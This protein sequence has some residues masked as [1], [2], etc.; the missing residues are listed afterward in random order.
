MIPFVNPPGHRY[1]LMGYLFLILVAVAAVEL[2]QWRIWYK[3]G[4]IVVGLGLVSGHFWLYP[5]GIAQG[6]DSS[7]AHLPVFALQEKTKAYFE[8]NGIP[9]KEVCADF[10]FLHTPYDTYVVPDKGDGWYRN[11]LEVTGCDWV[12]NSNLING[13]SNEQLAEFQ[14][15]ARWEMKAEYTARGMWVQIFHRR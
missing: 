1:F 4:L 6:W 8:T 13:Y 2:G 5:K 3:M 10:P 15:A 12:V 9:V 7:L 11:Y 14:D